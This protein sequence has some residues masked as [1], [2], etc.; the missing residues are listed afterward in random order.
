LPRVDQLA[1]IQRYKEFRSED[2]DNHP[3][4]AYPELLQPVLKASFPPRT[5]VLV[6]TLRGNVE[7]LY[8]PCASEYCEEAGPEDVE[9]GPVLEI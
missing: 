3:F 8:C 7:I 1:S 2:C 5:R 6:F 9:E 4:H